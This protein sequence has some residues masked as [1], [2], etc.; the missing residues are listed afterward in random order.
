MFF[1]IYLKFCKRTLQLDSSPANMVAN[2]GALPP[3]ASHNSLSLSEQ[4]KVALSI[5]RTDLGSGHLPQC[6]SNCSIKSLKNSV[7]VDPDYIRA[8]KTLT[9]YAGRIWYRWSRL[10]LL[11]CTGVYPRGAHPHRRWPTFL[12]QPDSSMKTSYFVSNSESLWM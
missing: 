7:P 11:T 3:A 2:K 6:C 9:V 12:L 1:Y 4:W 10:K 5:T 8:S